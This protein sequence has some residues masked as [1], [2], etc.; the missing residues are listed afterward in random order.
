[1]RTA[2][3]IVS[4]EVRRSA[5]TERADVVLPVAPAAEKAGRYV[6][7]EGRRRPF[8]LTLVGTGA[9]TDAQVLDALAEEMDVRLGLR[10]VGAARDELARLSAAG[11]AR[12]HPP[13]ASAKG[14]PRAAEGQA[15]LATW[16]ELLDAGRAQDGDEHLA[17]TAKPAR[18]LMSLTTAASHGLSA[19]EQ[20][21]VST[22]RGSILVPL[23]IADLPDQVVWLPTNARHCA[24]RA[25]LGAVHGSIVT[26][27]NPSAPPVVG[28]AS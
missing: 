7:W 1:L 19:G 4:L 21:A 13:T 18:A 20:V 11:G 27:T 12:V 16:P 6:T 15:V 5:V 26:V 8:D 24:V 17:G 10:T 3:F 2:G 25:T 14:A 23:E 28:G 9:L 22:E